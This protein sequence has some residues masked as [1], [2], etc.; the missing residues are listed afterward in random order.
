MS[1]KTM[2]M[3]TIFSAKEKKVEP[4]FLENENIIFVLCDIA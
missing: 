1:F 3:K 2:R 4:I